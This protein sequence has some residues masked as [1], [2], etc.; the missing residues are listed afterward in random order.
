[1]T[2]QELSYLAGIIDGEGTVNIA[3]IKKVVNTDQDSMWL[4]LQRF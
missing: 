2:K 4:I 3:F 1:M